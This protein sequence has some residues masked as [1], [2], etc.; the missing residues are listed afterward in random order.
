MRVLRGRG[1]GTF[2]TPGLIVSHVPQP[3]G[4]AVGDVNGDGRPDLAAA[5]KF[6]ASALRVLLNH[7]YGPGS[8]FTDLGG[9]LGGSNGFPIQ[10]A[11]GTLV[12]GQPFAFKLASGPP[13]G[14]AF[15]I[16]GLAALNAPFK[17]GLLIPFPHVVNGPLPL[18]ASGGITLA[19]NWPAGGSGLTQW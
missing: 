11:S 2:Y 6:G 8:P 7:T 17:G 15:H 13:S 10:L 14:V 18:N 4:L 9:S 1:D 12:A 5:T 3:Q 16:V 19:A